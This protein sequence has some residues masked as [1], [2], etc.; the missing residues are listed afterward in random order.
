[1]KYQ[2]QLAIEYHNLTPHGRWGEVFDSS[3]NCDCVLVA[4][5]IFATKTFK[6][7]SQG[8]DR[9]YIHTKEEN[10]S[11][12]ISEVSQEIVRDYIRDQEILGDSIKIYKS[13]ESEGNVV[14]MRIL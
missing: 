5:R 14:G 12:K 9:Y 11:W 3:E 4:Q 8:I 6:D 13:H 1:M 2:E 7:L 10:G